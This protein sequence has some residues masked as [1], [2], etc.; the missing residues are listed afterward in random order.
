[1]AKK[2]NLQEVETTRY[3]DW[4]ELELEARIEDALHEDFDQEELEFIKNMAGDFLLEL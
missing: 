4:E 3:N 1:M 2:D